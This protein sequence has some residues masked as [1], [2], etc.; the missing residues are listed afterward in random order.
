MFDWLERDSAAVVPEHSEV[1]LE[2]PVIDLV[3]VVAALVTDSSQVGT[4]QFT[5][6]ERAPADAKVS[7]EASGPEHIEPVT[8]DTR[9]G[10]A[11]SQ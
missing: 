5:P 4:S 2:P 8:T 7:P 9:A 11:V 1:H 10:V 3:L 6:R